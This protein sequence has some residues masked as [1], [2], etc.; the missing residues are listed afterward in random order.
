S[1]DGFT[2]LHMAVI[3]RKEEVVKV[4]LAAHADVEAKDAHGRT[5]LHW[6]PFAYRPQEVH[7]YMDIGGPHETEHV[8][9]GAAKAINLL[10]DAGA[11]INAV[12]DEGDTPLHEAA[13]LGSVRGAQALL[14]RGAKTNAKNNAGE[15]PLSIA[16]A[17]DHR[18]PVL[19]ILERGR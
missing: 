9:P 18:R 1:N 5:P 16:K 11:K 14:A 19:K 4:L 7:I 6:G 2:P 8:D 15:T 10:L 13:R 3:D 17:S 12:D